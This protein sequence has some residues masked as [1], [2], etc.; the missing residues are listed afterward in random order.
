MTHLSGREVCATTDWIVDSMKR[1]SLRAGVTSTYERRL[2]T[3]APYEE[4]DSFALAR[5]RLPC[6][7]APYSLPTPC[8]TLP[9][10][11]RTASATLDC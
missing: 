11:A 8:K 6:I 1:A 9:A 5:T 2:G 10:K 3:L 7:E 4:S